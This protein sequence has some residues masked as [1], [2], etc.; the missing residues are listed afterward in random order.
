MAQP[1]LEQAPEKVAVG[2]LSG[3]VETAFGFHIILRTQ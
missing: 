3:V 1:E 2:S